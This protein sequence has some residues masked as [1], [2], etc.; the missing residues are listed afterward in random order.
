MGCASPGAPPPAGAD[1]RAEVL[2]TE[3][4]F[5]RTMAERDHAA[6][7]SF[8]SEE[9]VFFSG[10]EALRGKARIVAYW[11]RFFGDDAAPF[12]WE[13][14]LVEVLDSGALALSSG[15]VHDATG[16]LVARF[17]SIWRREAPGTWRIVFDQGNDVCD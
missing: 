15:P 6:F 12:S 2:A 5:A 3:R 7:A 13:P 8:V 4:A 11:A 9:A 10:D 17:T 14:E 1:A 16:R